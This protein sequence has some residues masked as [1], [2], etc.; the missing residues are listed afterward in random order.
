MVVQPDLWLWFLSCS[1]GWQ[2]WKSNLSPLDSGKTTAE[3]L[4]AVTAHLPQLC[5]KI[6]LQL[7]GLT[8]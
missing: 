7:Q 2:F 1:E 5:E 4:A 8:G 6:V 3:T